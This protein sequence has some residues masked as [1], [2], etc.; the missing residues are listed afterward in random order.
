MN[1]GGLVSVYSRM[2]G[3]D[4]SEQ[5]GEISSLLKSRRGVGR[6]RGVA[7]ADA[8]TDGDRPARSR[9]DRAW[10]RRDAVTHAGRRGETD[11]RYPP[12]RRRNDPRQKTTTVNPHPRAVR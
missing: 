10:V 7:I 6:R 4:R 12:R 3:I 8:R 5:S 11:R 1:G 9:D 2:D